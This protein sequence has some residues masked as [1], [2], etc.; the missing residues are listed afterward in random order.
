MKCTCEYTALLFIL[1]LIYS[2]IYFS[3]S[4]LSLRVC[5]ILFD[6][7][8]TFQKIVLNNDYAPYI[9]FWQNSLTLK[10]DQYYCRNVY[11]MCITESGLKFLRPLKETHSQTWCISEIHPFK[12]TQ[13][14]YWLQKHL[15]Y[16][17]ALKMPI[18]VLNEDGSLSPRDTS[19]FKSLLTD[20]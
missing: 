9:E 14:V 11:Y 18:E 4:K 6:V 8:I 15:T 19:T 20:K 12:S 16:W 3:L 5:S 1:P 17:Q 7:N 10:K 13:M 2:F